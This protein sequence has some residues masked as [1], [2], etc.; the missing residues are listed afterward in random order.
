VRPPEYKATALTT[1]DIW[2]QHAGGGDITNFFSVQINFE[3]KCLIVITPTA[4]TGKKPQV[5]FFQLPT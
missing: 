3:D 4:S 2:W 5:D 1:R